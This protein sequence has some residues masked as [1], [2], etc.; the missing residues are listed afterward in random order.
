MAAVSA[1]AKAAPKPPIVFPV[2]GPVT[3]TDDFGDP[4][5]DGPAHQGNDLL[6]PR[7]ALALAAEGGTVE[8]WT[9]SR[10]A[11]C[12]LYL[13]GDSGTTYLYIHLNNDLGTGNDNKGSCV[14]GTAYA[15]DLVD[16]ARVEAG[17]PV[18]FVGDSGDANGIHPHL[19]FEV[20]PKGKDAVDPFPYLKKAQHL[21]FWEPDERVFTLVLD[22]TVTAVGDGTLTLAV[23][24]LKEWPSH[25]RSTK[26][27]RTLTV[28]VPLT[29]SQI[30]ASTT[31]APD[32]AVGDRV[33]VWTAPAPASADA[34]SGAAGAISLAKLLL[35]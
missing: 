9:T 33:R 14:P 12:M 7:K 29:A 35:R 27:G 6:A 5:G 28:T 8:F 21:L 10:N 13:H 34:R 32:A 19:H 22:G 31:V 26:L 30:A 17:Q 25:Q 11:G 24:T 16:G 1:S 23:D 2:L 15:P 20:H 4:R 18:G 3:Y